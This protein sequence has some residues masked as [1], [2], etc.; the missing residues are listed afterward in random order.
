MSDPQQVPDALLLMA[1]G[2]AHCP[3]VLNALTHLIEEGKIGRLEVIDVSR[4]PEAARQA[5]VR[6]VPWT[7][8]GPFEL[9][10]LQS[11]GDLSRWAERAA[12]GGGMGDYYAHL[13][14]SGRMQQVPPLIRRH[15]ETLPALIGL[16]ASLETPM[17]VRIG[18]GAVIEELAEQGELAPAVPELIRLTHAPEPQVRADACHY[19]SLAGGD[20]AV[21]A[22]RALLEDPD[23]EVR[24]IARESLASGDG[25]QRNGDG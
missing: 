7:R 11:R 14:E 18:V 21:A 5:G 9:E 2:C 16:M 24:A 13:L 25:A 17:A 10:G 3:S 12:A 22:I 6:S 8:I 20:E 15:P 4:H 19:L 23:P 1:R